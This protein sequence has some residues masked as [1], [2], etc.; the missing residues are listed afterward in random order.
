MIVIINGPY[1]VGKTS[2]AE[3]LIKK[4]PSSILFDTEE[5]GSLLDNLIPLEIRKES[6]KGNWTELESWKKLVVNIGI[7]LRKE[8]NQKLNFR[9]IRFA[10][11]VP[12]Q[13]SGIISSIGK[14][15]SF[16]CPGSKGKESLKE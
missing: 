9:S 6:E 12:S 16:D 7:F 14:P 4:I 11:M 8:Y 5:I 10:A 3:D 13:S 1:G 15:N 2:V